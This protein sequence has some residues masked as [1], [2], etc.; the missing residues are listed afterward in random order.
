MSLRGCLLLIPCEY[1]RTDISAERL[2]MALLY[3]YGILLGLCLSFQIASASPECKP[4]RG[5][6]QIWKKPSIHWVWVGETHGTQESP[7]VFGEMVCAALSQGLSVSVAIERPTS[8]Q[9]AIDRLMKSEKLERSRAYLLR[10]PDWQSSFDGR[11]SKAVLGLLER[12]RGLRTAYP[13]LSV[14]AIVDAGAF[15]SSPSMNDRMMGN[16][17]RALWK[18][19][20]NQL[21]MILTGNVHGFRK[22]YRGVKTAAMY[23]PSGQ[24]MSLEITDTGGKVWMRTGDGCGVQ[25]GGIVDKSMLRTEGVYLGAELAPVGFVDGIVALHKPVSPSP[26][27]TVST[28]QQLNDHLCDGS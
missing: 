18:G 4:P 20:H 27:A 17:I 10:Q 12:L 1:S 25:S 19:Q 2:A 22:P 15:A 23:I 9:G 14:Q 6:A 28:Q 3:R 24:I 21:V 8:E 26:P 11:T 5:V 7:A 13:S 16:N